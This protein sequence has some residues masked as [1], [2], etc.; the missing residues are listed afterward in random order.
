[1]ESQDSDATRNRKARAACG[2]AMSGAGRRGRKTMAA[3]SDQ[4]RA[5]SV[6]AALDR[7]ARK[8]AISVT[9]AVLTLLATL[10][11]LIF[12]LLAANAAGPHVLLFATLAAALTAAA[13]G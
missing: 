9:L 1:M 5:A 2:A 11:Y 6:R 3:Q 12:A 10:V 7:I 4:A 13:C 8:I